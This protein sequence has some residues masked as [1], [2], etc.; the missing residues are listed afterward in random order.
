MT[1]DHGDPCK[2]LRHLDPTSPPLDYIKHHGVFKAK[3][4]NEYDL[5]HFY[6]IELSRH[7][8]TFP[9]PT[10]PAT[11]EM[12]EDFLLKALALGHPNLIVAFMWDS[13]TVVCL[14]HELH[15]NDSLRCFP[16]EPKSDAGGKATKKLSFCLFY[17]YHSN[18]DLLHMNHIMCRHYH[19]NYSCG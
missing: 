7:L 3:K 13:A 5:C 4:S 11:H 10:E 19:A 2:E 1:C 15:S 12:L 18:N 8:P 9:S 16:M 17:L 14:L 6:C